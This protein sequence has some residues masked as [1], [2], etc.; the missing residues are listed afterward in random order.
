M[1]GPQGI[2][3]REPN[4]HGA[5]RIPGDAERALR[6][7]NT[8]CELRKFPTAGLPVLANAGAIDIGDGEAVASI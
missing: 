5:R 3:R 6:C 7:K 8:K 2:L 4:N 1:P